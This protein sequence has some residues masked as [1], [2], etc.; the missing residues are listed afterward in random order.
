VPFI[1]R[2]IA[3]PLFER[4]DLFRREWIFLVGGR[5][6]V[7][8]IMR[9]D[10]SEKFA[11]LGCARNNC[12]LLRFSSAEGSFADIE[13]QVAFARFFI[14][15][16]AGEA[17]VGEDW[18]DV[19][20]EGDLWLRETPAGEK[21]QQKISE[22]EHCVYCYSAK[23]SAT[24]TSSTMKNS[25]RRCYDPRKNFQTIYFDA[26]IEGVLKRDTLTAKV[27]FGGV[28]LFSRK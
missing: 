1:R 4:F 11:A 14:L 17:V 3:Y 27:R 12:R 2:A 10:A 5:H 23:I 8:P 20:V 24:S 21:E 13:A 28:A 26:Q 22:A 15:A 7:V 6:D 18:A 9:R 25:A 19:A 16:M